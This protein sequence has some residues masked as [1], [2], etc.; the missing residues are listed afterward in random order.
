[1]NRR[2]LV[3]AIGL[4]ALTLLSAWAEPRRVS[5]QSQREDAL[6]HLD[7]VDAVA[8]MRRG[9][10]SAEAYAQALLRRCER[11]A[12]LNA[13][14]T[15]RPETVL[16]AARAADRIRNRGA[17]LGPLHGLPIPIK[18]S[19]NTRDLPTTAGTNALRAFRPARD[20]E[21]VE[22][23]RAA[24]AFP[25]GKTNLHE[26][27]FGWSSSNRA[28]GPVRNAYD[29]AR[30]PGGSTGGTATA[31]AARMAPLGIAED[32]QGSIRVPAALCG[33]AGFRPTKNRYPNTGAAP[34]SSLFDQIGPHARSVADLALF[35]AVI[36]GDEQ[37]LPELSLRGLRFAVLRDFHFADI[38]DEIATAFDTLFA[39]LRNA[40]VD[41]VEAS[42]PELASFERLVTGPVQIHDVVPSLRNYLRESGAPVDLAGLLAE[43][44]PDIMATFETFCLPGA[45]NAISDTIYR[46]AR[47]LH[48][49]RLQKLLAD[50]YAGQGIDAILF[51]P[52][53]VTAPEIGAAERGTVGQRN[54]PFATAMGRNIAPG[55]TAGIPGLVLPLG[56]GERSRLPIG[57]ELDGAA[58][59]DRRL[60]AIGAAVSRLLAPMP[61]PAL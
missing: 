54:L 6:C 51:P 42:I 18:D 38:D 32:T 46:A 13:F 11:G 41:I 43:L 10:V 33:I 49:P 36:T 30:I 12:A 4:A 61:P 9:D 14:I 48:R 50:F 16:E 7:A 26:L 2:E 37:P 20:A 34:I 17:A 19:V 3:N 55:S 58:G 57:L 59:T 45:P 44:S 1:M 53:L 21:I 35:D 31:I 40:G 52:T 60:L 22:R 15:L 56:L 25:L 27:S 5:M 39:T 23:L 28:F 29:T 8:A 47:D 24:G